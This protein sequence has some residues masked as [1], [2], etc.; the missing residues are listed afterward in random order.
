MIECEV[1]FDRVINAV[2]QIGYRYPPGNEAVKTLTP[3]WSVYNYA[4]AHNDVAPKS[5]N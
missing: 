2:R 5:A 4:I 1:I 3:K